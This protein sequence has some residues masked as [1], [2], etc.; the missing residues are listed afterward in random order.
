MQD[1]LIVAQVAATLILLVSAALLANSFVRMLLVD[2]GF[3]T[4][5]LAAVNVGLSAERYASQTARDAFF[6]D[7]PDS[8]ASAAGRARGDGRRP[9]ASGGWHRRAAVRGRRRPR[10]A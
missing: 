3:E 10:F 7:C 5:N 8:R 1:A 4:R 2:P 9:R 6:D